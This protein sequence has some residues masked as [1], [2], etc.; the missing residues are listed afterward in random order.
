MEALFS[1]GSHLTVIARL[2]KQDCFAVVIFAENPF[3]YARSHALPA[4]E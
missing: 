2:F 1:S 3:V 4:P